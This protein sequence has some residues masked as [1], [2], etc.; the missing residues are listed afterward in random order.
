MLRT[1]AVATIAAACLVATPGRADINAAFGNTVLSRYPDGGWVKH[2]F[3]PDGT[4]AAQF[5]DGR[6]LSARWAVRGEKL[7]LTN[8][9][10]NMLIPRFCTEMIEASVGETWQSRDPLGRRVSNVLIA[11]R[12]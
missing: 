12:N 7:C 4:Y 2:W 6:R 11:G 3:N 9:R 8:I 1:L 10:P 5:S